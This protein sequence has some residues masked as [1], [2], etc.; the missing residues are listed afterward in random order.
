MISERRKSRAGNGNCAKQFLKL[1]RTGGYRDLIHNLSETRSQQL[2][3]HHIE[4]ITNNYCDDHAQH[5]CT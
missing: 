2:H 5:M 3:V 4:I 1:K